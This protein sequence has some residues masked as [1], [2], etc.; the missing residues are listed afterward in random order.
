MSTRT[1]TLRNT[2][3]TSVAI[4]T[5]YFLGMLTS[6]LIA[7]NLGPDG[8]GA[9]SL[10]I[11]LVAV[12]M[13]V[14]NAG[15]AGAVIRFV[16][17]LRGAGTPELIVP[18]LAFL[19]RVQRWFL[20]V[21]LAGGAA[22]FWFAGDHLVPGFNHLLLFL[23]MALSTALRANYMFNVCIAK[24][25][26]HF[27]AT[28]V[29][30]TVAAPANLLLVALAWWVSAPVEGFLAVYAVSSAVFYFVSSRQTRGLLPDAAA[31]LALPGSV[32][33][34][35]VRHMRITA[36]MVIITYVTASEVEVMFL[37]LLDTAAAAGK[38]KVAY[39]LADGA[40]LLVPG[41][42]GVLLLPMM[43]N[44]LSQSREAA[45]RRFV[46]ATTYLALLAMPLLAFG[47]LFAE[48]VMAVLY[49]KAYLAA[50]PAFAVILLAKSVSVVSQ[51]G[52]SLLMSSERQNVV[53]VI[54]ILCGLLKIA[55]DVVLIRRYGL[56]GAIVAYAVATIASAAAM[57]VFG[58]RTGG[59]G[60]PWG[61]LLRIGGAGAIAALCA[62]PLHWLGHPLPAVVAGFLVIS[63]SYAFATLLLG[64][65]S[66]ADIA[67]IRGMHARL[68]SGRPRAVDKLLQ[69]AGRRA[70][71]EAT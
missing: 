39:Q 40:T 54:V 31:G 18:L 4:Y 47:I 69:W 34:R 55:L 42:F 60:L 71:R 11:W 53:L 19:R 8:F 38:F 17:E 45:G 12:S 10:I 61:R 51:G 9:Y 70:A 3:F 50:A 62:L 32:H 35:V 37:N 24:G 16:A 33:A 2:A 66:E 67:H 63:L 52:S 5:E 15:T 58:A 7:R 56:H 25:F 59:T 43:A 29:I 48:P 14:V 49:G 27:R 23:L 6:I 36:A 64:C 57:I 68:A 30:A 1:T 26:E 22:L 65:W 13:T 41:V 28:A 21:V 20:L 46:G 44:A